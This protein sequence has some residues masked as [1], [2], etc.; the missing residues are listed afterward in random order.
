MAAAPRASGAPTSSLRV[1]PSGLNSKACRLLK[2]LRV[3]L[4]P[5]SMEGAC[6]AAFAAVLPGPLASP[7]PPPARAPP[8]RAQLALTLMK[9]RGGIAAGPAWTRRE[10]CCRALS[11][12]AR[13]GG[14][15][16]RVGR[17]LNAAPGLK[18]CRK[19][20][21][22]AVAEFFGPKA[23][24]AQSCHKVGLLF[25]RSSI[26]QPYTNYINHGRAWQ[27]LWRLLPG[28]C[29]SQLA[30]GGSACPAELRRAWGCR[31]LS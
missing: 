29:G 26:H 12:A 13:R 8:P 1:M 22:P 27:P 10:S 14:L 4:G 24:L 30:L 6:S 2:S 16:G 21:E 7:P 5:I 15:Y 20:A 28:D 18:P 31:A 23:T 3:P 19:A 17:S 11:R 25:D 9:R